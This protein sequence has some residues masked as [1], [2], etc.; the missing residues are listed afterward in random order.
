MPTAETGIGTQQRPRR[1]WAAAALH[2]GSIASAISTA[3]IALLSRHRT[4]H[5]ASATNATSHWLW[6]RKA[7]R[8]DDFSLRYTATGY[9]IHHLSSIWWAMFYAGWLRRDGGSG[10]VAKAAA[11]ATAALVV[12]YAVVPR[13]LTPGFEARL[14]P[15]AIGCIYVAFAAG[16]ALAA[17]ARRR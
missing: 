2:F 13:R 16:L 4:G 17:R 10:R 11:V 1:S 15:A 7:F 6:Q 14:S 12:D 8:Q 9:L 5:L 3:A